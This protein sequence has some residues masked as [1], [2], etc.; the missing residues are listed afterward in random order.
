MCKCWFIN[1]N[2]LTHSFSHP[3]ITDSNRFTYKSEYQL[4]GTYHWG[5]VE[6]YDGGGY[7]QNFPNLDDPNGTVKA[8]NIIEE[9]EVC[10]LLR[11]CIC[12]CVCMCV[13]M[14]T[15]YRAGTKRC[16]PVHMYTD[17]R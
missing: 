3:H 8:L 2:A 15:T 16:A 10:N 9:L 6:Y 1:S 4:E 12:V 17:R 7:V 11:V 5:W 13:R 14:C